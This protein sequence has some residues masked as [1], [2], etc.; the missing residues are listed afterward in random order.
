MAGE[1][2]AGGSAGVDARAAQGPIPPDFE[3]AIAKVDTVLDLV[4]THVVGK[5]P[6][7][8]VDGI[9]FVD[10][11]GSLWHLSLLQRNAAG[12]VSLFNL[13]NPNESDLYESFTIGGRM[14]ARPS[15]VSMITTDHINPRRE[16]WDKETELEVATLAEARLRSLLGIPQPKTERQLIEETLEHV[17]I[18]N[19]IDQVEQP[20]T[21]E[22][23]YADLESYFWQ[24]LQPPTNK[25][26]DYT[27][28]EGA[29]LDL[30]YDSFDSD[31]LKLLEGEDIHMPSPESGVSIPVPEPDTAFIR[32]SDDAQG[33]VIRLGFTFKGESEGQPSENFGIEINLAEAHGT[34]D[35][36]ESRT[37]PDG[38]P[39]GAEER[40]KTEKAQPTPDQMRNIARILDKYSHS[41]AITYRATR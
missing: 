29:E 10:P 6:N 28:D 25:L 18:H 32:L 35:I 27:L 26:V 33:R 36:Y 8:T 1:R 22:Q 5:F 3:Q 23:V 16:R 9:G 20:Q 38:T 24:Q 30:I 40:V 31:I 7:A 13:Q 21:F 12:R 39:Q 41:G 34:V 11:D 19:I 17:A 37:S 14:S 15:A 4:Q 2:L